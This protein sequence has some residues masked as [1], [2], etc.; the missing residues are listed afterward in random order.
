MRKMTRLECAIVW[1]FILVLWGFTVGAVH[2][3][4]DNPLPKKTGERKSRYPYYYPE[5]L[6]ADTLGVD[7]LTVNTAGVDTL[8]VNEIGG[9][10]LEQI[11]IDEFKFVAQDVL[12]RTTASYETGATPGEAVLTEQSSPYALA[13]A[14]EYTRPTGT[15]ND[16]TFLRSLVAG[17]EFLIEE[18]NGTKYALGVLASAG[19]E[20]S[21]SGVPCIRTWTY[22][23][24]AER[25]ED[26]YNELPFGSAKIYFYRKAAGGGGGGIGPQGPAGPAGPAFDL[27]AITDENKV[28][29]DDDRFVVSDESA[30]GDPNEY[31]RADSLASYV[32]KEIDPVEGLPDA[33]ANQS[34][35]KKYE[36]NVPASSGAATWTEAQSGG[37]GSGDITGVTAG[38]GLSGGGQSGAV[39]LSVTNPFTDSD[40]TKL[41]GLVGLPAYPSEGSRDNKVPKFAGN[42]LGW[43]VDA[44]G[45][46]G[47]GSGNIAFTDTTFWAQG[48]TGSCGNRVV[49]SGTSL[50]LVYGNKTN[51]TDVTPND[52]TRALDYIIDYGNYD[53]LIFSAG[54]LGGV[55]L[56]V[57][58]ITKNPFSG[59][60][61][62]D[63]IGFLTTTEGIEYSLTVKSGLSLSSNGFK[64]DVYSKLHFFL[65]A[66]VTTQT[67]SVADGDK[68]LIGD[69][70][71]TGT[72]NR[73]VQAD[74]LK[75]YVT[76]TISTLLADATLTN[77]DT[78]QVFKE[79]G[80]T[81]GEMFTY[82]DE[83]H[84]GTQTRTGYRYVTNASPTTAGDI[85]FPATGTNNITFTVKPKDN[86]DKVALL[87]KIRQGVQ[88][89]V[90]L[91]STVYVSCVSGGNAG[92]LFTRVFWTAN[93]CQRQG[94]PTNNHAASIAL[95]NNIPARDEFADVAFS[96][97]Y[98]DLT[99]K[100]GAFDLDAD[101]TTQ[102]LSVADGD[103][104][105]IGD[106]SETGTPNRW[107]RADSLKSYVKPADS[108]G[109]GGG[110]NYPLFGT[111]KGTLLDYANITSTASKV[112]SIQITPSSTTAKYLVTVT[113]RFQKTGGTTATLNFT[114]YKGA[115]ELSVSSVPYS[116]MTRAINNN[117]DVIGFASEWVWTPG[118]TDTVKLFLYGS[119]FGQNNPTGSIS[120]LCFYLTK[121]A[122]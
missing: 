23:L 118:S 66:D 50:R 83:H 101:V 111:K 24:D 46:G 93:T 95:E 76:P 87:A 73:W 26:S 64:V 38:T 41:D 15:V 99:N 19:T 84:T 14:I 78:V 96:G 20:A 59:R 53:L 32:E 58:A 28:L 52:Y 47:G 75:S 70:S 48:A 39:T 6:R 117:S 21:C 112:D 72:P 37:G 115:S 108:G 103:K 82:H 56:G 5:P 11:H 94:T 65:D 22:T 91:S 18:Q 89:G 17:D 57:T 116:G 33:P 106:V 31:V 34:T 13:I 88:F 54:G 1:G 98:E 71:E 60:S 107:V 62:Q 102:T 7:T 25:G 122:D 119:A 44:T 30:T 69:V 104:V 100:P 27:H 61:C 16:S 45:S 109:G 77:A 55:D 12:N 74:S 10:G 49:Y 51:Q 85:N 36:L 120:S 3:W 97:D 42:T 81:V 40:E 114:Y 35:V 92:E 80:V 86:A 4:G 90:H 29:A 68:V 67:L 43:E 121:V 110:S 9:K 2:V 79:R 105:L 8:T 63:G 113:G